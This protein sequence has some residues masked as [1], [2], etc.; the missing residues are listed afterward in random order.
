MG[1][2]HCSYEGCFSSVTSDELCANHLALK[3]TFEKRM[4]MAQSETNRRKDD[5]KVED[6]AIVT[7]KVHKRR[8]SDSPMSK[9]YPKYYKPIPEGLTE[10][11]VYAVCR[12]FNVRDAELTHAIKK[13]MLPGERTGGKTRYHDI[14]EAR[15]TLNRWMEL[16][17]IFG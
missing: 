11:D 17:T 16:E 2:N 14:K 10:V 5:V 15:D 3:Q 4:H 12:I 8:E 13:I 7:Y 1:K 9:L 6:A